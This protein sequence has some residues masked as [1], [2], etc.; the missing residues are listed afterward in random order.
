M[1]HYNGRLLLAD[2]LSAWWHQ[3]LL[4]SRVLNGPTA[5]VD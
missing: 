4:L 2:V 1:A 5:P 3:M